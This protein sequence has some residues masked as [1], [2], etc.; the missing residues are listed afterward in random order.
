MEYGGGTGAVTVELLKKLPQDGKLI[1]VELQDEF[2]KVLR[3]IEDPRLTV[4]HDNVEVC[5]S[6]L[7]EFYKDGPDAVVCGIPFLFFSEASRK[8][9]IQNTKE[10][11]NEHG[12]FIV[13]QHSLQLLSQLKSTF[14]IVKLD[15]ELRNFPPYIVMTAFK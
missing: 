13:Y 12:R 3:E 4:L 5:S 1:V 6:K 10:G 8:T 14:N 2:V 9:I 11:M 15:L 7:R